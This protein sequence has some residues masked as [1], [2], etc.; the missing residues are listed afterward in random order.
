VT[1]STPSTVFYRREY[2]Q[3]LW[4]PFLYGIA[5]ASP[6]RGP[7]SWHAHRC[8]RRRSNDDPKERGDENV[9]RDEICALRGNCSRHRRYG[10]GCDQATEND[11]PIA[12]AYAFR[13]PFRAP[14]RLSTHTVLQPQAVVPL[15]TIKC[16][17]AIDEKAVR[18]RTSLNVPNA[19][20]VANGTSM[21]VL[22]G[23]SLMF[24]TPRCQQ[25]AQVSGTRI[26]R[27]R[28]HAR[29][30]RSARPILRVARSTGVAPASTQIHTKLKY[31][32][33]DCASLEE[34]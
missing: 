26:G 20:R 23:T 31:I 5:Y 3:A 18:K 11:S 13:R 4:C 10:I 6:F 14:V 2:C 28:C 25:F 27:A 34:R 29:G 16:S 19:A 21:A 32:R 22:K 9:D 12:A 30:R 17:S 15:A 1:K 24:P 7:R 8:A 33:T